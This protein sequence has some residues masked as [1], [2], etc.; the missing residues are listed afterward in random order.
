MYT[1]AV[2]IASS[3]LFAYGSPSALAAD[4]YAPSAGGLKDPIIQQEV[5]LPEAS[6]FQEYAEWYI[7]GD[8]GVGKYSG[9]DKNGH[10]A[11]TAFGINALDFDNIYS[12]SVGFGRYLT[13]NIRLGLDVDYRHHSTST[14]SVGVPGGLPELENFGTVPLKFN[15]TSIMLNAVYDFAPNRRFSPYLGGGVGWAFHKLSLNG[16]TFDNDFDL[17]DTW[18][19][20]T[21]NTTNSSSNS[22]AANIVTGVSVNIKQGLFLDV[23]YKFSYLGKASMDFDYSHDDVVGG[24][25]RSASMELDDIMTHEFKVGL[26]YDL[27]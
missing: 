12:A 8:L 1:R 4:I 2:F 11:G 13:P 9:I 6:A 20:G 26:R 25:S 16:S 15:S 24:V 10:I 22:F 14:F 23:G 7:R 5:L 17:D 19:N 21:V 27:Y 18:E 3:I